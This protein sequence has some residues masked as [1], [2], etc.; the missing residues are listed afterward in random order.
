MQHTFW[1]FRRAAIEV[2]KREGLATVLAWGA[3]SALG[4]GLLAVVDYPTPF[5]TSGLITGFVAALDTGRSLV[6]AYRRLAARE[7]RNG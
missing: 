5:S 7:P 1:L 4:A 3:A 6:G 2:A